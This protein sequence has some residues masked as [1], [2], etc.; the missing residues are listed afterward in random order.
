MLNL[1]STEKFGFKIAWYNEVY[2]QLWNLEDEIE[3]VYLDRYYW[4]IEN[5]GR[6][7]K[8]IEEN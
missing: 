8:L 4:E 5:I 7:I 2:Q 6:S 3:N 1:S